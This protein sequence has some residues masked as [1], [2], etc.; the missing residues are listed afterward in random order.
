MLKFILFLIKEN[1]QLMI[2][3]DSF[4]DYFPTLLASSRDK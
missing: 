3:C 1:K 4:V 2:Y